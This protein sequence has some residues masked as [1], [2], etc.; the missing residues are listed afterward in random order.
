MSKSVKAKAIVFDMDGTLLDSL[1]YW[2]N[3][4]LFAA[5]AFGFEQDKEIKLNEQPGTFF[6][7]IMNYVNCHGFDYDLDKVK[8]ELHRV[9]IDYY[10]SE[11]IP[12]KK[13][14]E[15]IEYVLSQGIRI[16]I[17]TAT[18]GRVAT[19]ALEYQ[20]MLKYF[21]FVLSNDDIGVSKRHPDIYLLAA[22][23]LGASIENT[24]VFEDNCNCVQTAKKAGFRVAGIKDHNFSEEENNITA[25]IADWNAWDYEYYLE[26]FKG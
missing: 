16:G 22:E 1:Y 23:K 9:G 13:A 12:K 11:V 15:F 18:N 8:Q 5:K 19:K 3:M 24:I 14:I 4:D 17:A 6:E 20:D 21:E 26:L 10:T 2:R 7:R 25:D